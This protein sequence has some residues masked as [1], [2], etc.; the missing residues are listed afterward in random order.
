MLDPDKIEEIFNRLSRKIPETVTA[1]SYSSTFELLIAVMLSAR[2]TDNIVN[3]VTEELFRTANTPE[4]I[5]KLGID[6][7]KFQIKSSGFYNTKA[8]HI[9]ETCRILVTKFNSSVPSDRKNLEDLPGVGRKTA[10]V[11]LNIAFGESTIAVDTHVFR[12][13]NRLG[14]AKGK[15]PMEVEL[16]L[17]KL[18]PIKLL[19]NAGMLLIIHGRQTCKARQPQCE[20]CVLGDL[21]SFLRESKIRVRTRVKM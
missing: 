14:L 9:M 11:V 6:R 18:I 19:K 4:G 7:L 16:S 12:V 21:C 8:N 2:T 1:L 10:N 13:A 20:N 15:T 17:M 3:K 5:L